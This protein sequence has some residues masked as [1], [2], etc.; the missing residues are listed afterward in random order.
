MWF[1]NSA[2]GGERTAWRNLLV[3]QVLDTPE[4]NEMNPQTGTLDCSLLFSNHVR[5]R[6]LIFLALLPSHPPDEVPVLCSRHCS[7]PA[8]AS[9][10][11]NVLPAGRPAGAGIS[12]ASLATQHNLSVPYSP[13]SSH[14][15]H[16]PFDHKFTFW[17]SK[18][19]VWSK[20]VRVI[21]P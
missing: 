11:S 18:P 4:A 6:P 9:S 7:L 19:L 16:T 12:Q 2:E 1:L 10:P 17:K 3:G 21:P 5:P 15:K 20:P 13:K 8:A 14:V